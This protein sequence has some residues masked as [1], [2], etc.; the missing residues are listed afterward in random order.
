F[1]IYGIPTTPLGS[2]EYIATPSWDDYTLNAVE[3]LLLGRRGP[4][5][6]GSILTLG[7]Y[8]R[9]PTGEKER[10]RQRIIRQR[11]RTPEARKKRLENRKRKRERR[12]EQRA[13]RERRR[14]Q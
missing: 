9:D 1:T 8:D 13:E 11:S 6:P 10:E 3:G 2:L 7:R 4:E 14:S 12:A 5:A